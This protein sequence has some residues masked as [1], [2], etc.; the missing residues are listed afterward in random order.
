MTKDEILIALQKQNLNFEYF[1]NWS[2][3][4]IK[5]RYLL[6]VKPLSG[7]TKK[8]ILNT[9]KKRGYYS[10]DLQ[11]LKLKDLQN[12]ILRN[13]CGSYYEINWTAA[14]MYAGRKPELTANEHYLD[15]FLN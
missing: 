12:R 5:E 15:L 2:L 9:L 7:W 11:N 1:K 8:T 3:K 13:I 10:K 4:K 6:N 14:S